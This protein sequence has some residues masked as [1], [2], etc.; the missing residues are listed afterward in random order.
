MNKAIEI[1]EASIIFGIPSKDIQPVLDRS[2]KIHSIIEFDDGNY[3]FSA[4]SN[5]MKIPIILQ[6]IFQ[7]GI[8]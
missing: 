3:I 7:I 1:V 5:S 6:L 2:S 4:S 8:K